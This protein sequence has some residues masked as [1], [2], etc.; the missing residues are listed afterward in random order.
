MATTSNPAL[1]QLSY[2]FIFTQ[3][4]AVLILSIY[5]KYIQSYLSLTPSVASLD[6][7]CSAQHFVATTVV[8]EINV[9]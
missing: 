1:V 4:R 3:P 2:L 7:V 9:L 8:S 5:P 6:V